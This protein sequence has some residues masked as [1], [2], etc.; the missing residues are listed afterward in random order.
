MGT[1]TMHIIIYCIYFVCHGRLIISYRNKYLYSLL[2][3]WQN[4][5]TKILQCKNLISAPVNPFL[6]P[7]SLQA[8]L[9]KG[10]FPKTLRIYGTNSCSIYT[11]MLTII[12]GRVSKQNIDGASLFSY[13][14][15]YLT[16][17]INHFCALYSM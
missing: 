4:F 3:L 16:Y 12:K 9:M 5:C 2:T 6:I 14:Y 8:T 11:C 13:S 7:V 17:F 15:F 1:N 10:Y